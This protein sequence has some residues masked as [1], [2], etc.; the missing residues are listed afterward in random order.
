MR[1]WVIGL[2]L[3]VGCNAA[4]RTQTALEEASGGA[5]IAA[6][7][8]RAE[9]MTLRVNGE[10]AMGTVVY[11]NT[12]MKIAGLVR[13]GDGST[14]Y[15]CNY[16]S[17]DPEVA[18]VNPGGFLIAKKVGQAT[19]TA[20][21]IDDPRQSTSVTVR[22]EFP[23]AADTLA[24]IQAQPAVVDLGTGSSGGSGGGTSSGTT[25]GTNG[26]TGGGTSPTPQPAATP[27]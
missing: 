15:R 12:V 25:G 5:A 17:S 16:A 26:G 6:A 21:S 18:S 27:Y 19:L 23:T 4:P 1:W 2:L 7:A 9:S 22:V 11:R 20:S 8:Q 14:N 3:V 10:D 13:M 24:K